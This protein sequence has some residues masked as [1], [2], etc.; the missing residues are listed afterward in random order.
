MKK[1]S[2]EFVARRLR[3]RAGRLDRTD[4]A[5]RRSPIKVKSTEL[6]PHAV[7]GLSAERARQA[8]KEGSTRAAAGRERALH[9]RT[10]A[11]EDEMHRLASEAARL[12]LNSSRGAPTARLSAQM[13]TGGG[14]ARE[15]RS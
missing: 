8:D 11:L 1:K 7:A 13:P 4:S 15:R 3:T 2:R 10:F 6:Q 9:S 14:C 5:E 12:R